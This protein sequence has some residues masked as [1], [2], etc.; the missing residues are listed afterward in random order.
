MEGNYCVTFGQAEVGNVQ[1]RREGLYW[2]FCCRCRITGDVV[3]RLV[4]QCGN[5][6]ES[7]GI[8]VPDGDVF[9]L[10]TRLPAKKLEQ[11]IPQFVLIPRHEVGEGTFVPLKPEEPFAY[12]AK[13]KD[14]YF[15]RRYGQAG[16]MIRE[17]TK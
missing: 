6:R 3:C 14:A 8:V 1:V 12:I 2:R 7:L 17:V 9:H 15:T 5:S 13:L 10:D 4:V 11:G 16:V